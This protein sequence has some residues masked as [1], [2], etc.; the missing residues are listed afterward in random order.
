MASNQ[1]PVA[2]KA[3][4]ISE[5]WDIPFEKVREIQRK[6]IADSTFEELKIRYNDPDLGKL[7]EWVDMD[8]VCEIIHSAIRNKWHPVLKSTYTKH[9][10]YLECWIKVLM[11]SKKIREVGKEKYEGFIY[12]IAEKNI[13]YRTLYRVKHIKKYGADI[14]LLEV[15][16]L[17][18]NQSYRTT[19]LPEVIYNLNETDDELRELDRWVYSQGS[20][21]VSPDTV[22]SGS[23]RISNMENA[24]L[25]RIEEEQSILYTIQSI[26]D[27][28]LR[29]LI[30][31]SAYVL[32]QLDS[33]KGLYIE[34]LKRMEKEK[35]NKF[36]ELISGKDGKV[37]NFQK[38]TKILVGDDVDLY[39]AKVKDYLQRI[40]VDSK[41]LARI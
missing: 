18:N 23:T 32:A 15:L 6:D 14:H 16:D 21:N 7:P 4:I 33:F 2:E 3:K 26:K 10:L 31:I 35:R 9:D 20:L 34:A 29:D 13:T 12:R 19:P 22:E 27:D 37:A 1:L 11:A 36:I 25:D 38:I 24:I 5:A 40:I 28:T 17:A 8:K 39:T 41:K 30:S